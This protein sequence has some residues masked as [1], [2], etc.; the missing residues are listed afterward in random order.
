MRIILG[1][2]MVLAFVVI[3]CDKEPVCESDDDC[4][5]ILVCKNGVCVRPYGTEV[6]E[7]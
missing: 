1:L 4:N 6:S 7:T 2:V 5:W 3:A